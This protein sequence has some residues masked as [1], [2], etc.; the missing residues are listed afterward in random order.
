MSR[1]TTACSARALRCNPSDAFAQAIGYPRAPVDD[2]LVFHIVFGKTVPDISL[3]AVANLGYADCRFLAPVYP[4][5][6]LTAVSEVI[7]LKENSS[8]KTGIVYVRTTGYK[9]DG[10]KVLEYVRWVM[11]RQARRERR[12]RPPTTCRGCRKRCCRS[13]SA[14]P[15][16]RSTSRLTTSRSPAAPTASAITRS[17]RRSTMST[18]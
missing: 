3:N 12:R 13:S 18:A 8:R 2:L 11:V 5:D 10:S 1:S 9:Q 15:A 7:G 17:A 6:T 16:R 14:T 4:G